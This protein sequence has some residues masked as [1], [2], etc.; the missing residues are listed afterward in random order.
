MPRLAGI[1]LSC[2]SKE[3][4]MFILPLDRCIL[5]R[6]GT[7]DS[8]TDSGK[9]VGMGDRL[10]VIA[11]VRGVEGTR[12]SAGARSMSTAPGVIKKGSMRVSS[13]FFYGG[14]WSSLE[15]KFVVDARPLTDNNEPKPKPKPAAN[16][17]ITLR[18]SSESKSK[19]KRVL[20]P[21]STLTLTAESE[22]EPAARLAPRME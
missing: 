14:L 1:S 11:K 21:P 19:S 20:L 12:M 17:Q 18:A 13:L 9:G 4:H 15:K 2:V 7:M 10:S 3:E 8:G 16:T 5:V 22:P 6:W